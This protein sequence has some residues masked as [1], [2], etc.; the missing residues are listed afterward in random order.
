MATSQITAALAHHSF[1]EGL[2]P[3][4]LDK[5]AALAC[6]VSFEPDEVIFREGDPSSFFYLILEGTIALEIAAPHRFLTIQ[7]VGE[8]EELGWSSLLDQVNKQFR[9]RCLT[10]VR[11]LA[12]DGVRLTATFETDHE[13]G[14]MLLRKV[15]AVVAERLRAT[16]LQVLD[17]Y[18]SK[19]APAK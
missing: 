18:A 4:H 15:M 2:L 13:F 9:A 5:L 17:I 8:G 19:G 7:T 14:Y 3:S 6:E 16:R 12:F 11:A 10:Q 1:L